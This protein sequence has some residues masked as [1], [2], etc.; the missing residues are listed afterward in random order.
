METKLESIKTKYMKFC[1]DDFHTGKTEIW[2]V[3]NIRSENRL[4]TI[5]WYGAWRQYCFYPESDCV[6]NK[7]CMNDIIKFIESCELVRN[8]NV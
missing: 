2:Y 1:K 4:G 5:K 6:F 7:D 3:Y 8:N